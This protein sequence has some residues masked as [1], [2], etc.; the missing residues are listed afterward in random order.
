MKKK[1][2]RLNE[3]KKYTP[4]LFKVEEIV[5]EE[6]L[7]GSSTRL[8]PGNEDDLIEVTDWVDDEI[9]GDLTW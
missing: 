3:L 5:S 1:F 7:A 6:S 8:H 4:P 9:N 2:L